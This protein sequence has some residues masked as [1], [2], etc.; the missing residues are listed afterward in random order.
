[1]RALRPDD[2]AR[3]E[4]PLEAQAKRPWNRPLK[5]RYVK[6]GAYHGKARKPLMDKPPQTRRDV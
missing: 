5:I 4:R 2:L 1:M 3:Y 6:G